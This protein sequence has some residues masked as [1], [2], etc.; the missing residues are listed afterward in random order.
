MMTNMNGR[1][2]ALF[3]VVSL[4]IWGCHGD[5]HLASDVN[6]V[7]LQNSTKS[8]QVLVSLQGKVS[9]KDCDGAAGMAVIVSSPLYGNVAHGMYDGLG[10][11]TLS[12]SA[13]ANDTVTIT[14]TVSKSYG[15]IFKEIKAAVPA[16][17]G[18]ITQDFQ[19]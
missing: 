12:G 7:L 6:D 14:V 5:T 16:G 13:R 4:G 18:T 8:T 3:A 15:P 19:F 2:L 9:C 17:G 11:Y 10:S 1:F